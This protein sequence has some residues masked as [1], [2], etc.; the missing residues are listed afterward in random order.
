[1]RKQL[2]VTG[3]ALGWLTA[4]AGG[5][6][7]T[8]IG[9]NANRNGRSAVA[10]PDAATVLWHN[11]ADY[12]IIAWHP[13][14]YDGRVYVVRE[15]NFPQN[16]GSA[17]DAIVAYDLADGHELWRVTI[18]F[19]GNT[20]QDWIAWIAGVEGG[21]VYASR[22]SNGKPR[23][24]YAYDAVTGDYLWT[25][26]WS[27]EAFAYDGA[28]FTPEGD[29]LV[30]DFSEVARVSAADGST[31]WATPRS[32][33]VSGNCG[34]AAASTMT[35]VYIDE[36]AAG[37]Q[38]ITKL[39]L[40]TGVRLYSSPV[41]PGFTEQNTPFVSPDETTVYLSRT[42]NNPSVDYLWA[43]KDTGTALIDYWHRPIRW[44]TSHSYGIGADGSIY[45]FIPGD[46]FVR[47]DPGSGNVLDT[48]GVLGP[49]GSP[50]T[51]VDAAGRVYL[52]NGWASNPATSGRLW[53]F[54]AD[55]SQS[56]F[57]LTLDRQNQGGPALGGWGV[58]VVAD[59]VGVHAYGPSAPLLG[60]LNCDG[61]VNFDDI[62]PFV[63]ALSDPAG[64]AAAYPDCRLLNG[65]CDGDG[66]VDFD[67]INGFV[68]LLSGG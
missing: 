6:D 25:S 9:G 56:L 50:H 42:Q 55:L 41:M 37:G 36:A 61:V 52:S 23:P 46:E 45:T 38:V 16:G 31:V 24:I 67:D 20:N 11:N 15:W 1:M 8:N 12:S 57:T 5:Q 68:A 65:D 33:S 58:L 22:G 49:L 34:P 30:G 35:A 48:A 47:L 64:Y 66:D 44:T 18:P 53:A 27:T 29:L 39:D 59:R 62:N 3:F 32:C 10:G 60:D 19:N 51:A 17:N 14:V 43:F 7:W 13:F 40:A 63:L 4:V 54:N 28:V 2:S 26:Q 21:Q